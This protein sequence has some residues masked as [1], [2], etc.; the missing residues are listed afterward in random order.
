MKKV[1]TLIMI[2]A[3]T[4]SLAACGG[5]EGSSSS[6][7]GGDSSSSSEAGGDTEMSKLDEIKAAGQIVMATSPDYPPFEYIYVDE[8]GNDTVVGADIQL[9]QYIAD[10]LGVELVVESMNFD[11]ILNA[12]AAGQADFALSGFTYKP[13]RAEAF[14][15]AGPFHSEGEQTILIAADDET[16]YTS[17]ND[18]S[19][20]K[21]GA[22]GG[23]LQLD[24]AN[25]IEGA[26]VL[27]FAQINE[28][29]LMLQS[30]AIDGLVIAEIASA[31]HVEVNAD[32]EYSGVI[33]EDYEPGLYA[34]CSLDDEAFNQFLTDTVIEADASGDYGTWVD[35]HEELSKS[36]ATE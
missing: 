30:G 33:F 31:T 13:E 36:Q 25:G 24:L 7:A 28:G 20:K 19:G 2:L 4:L 11:A 8:D 21:L 17:V 10:A 26:E 3:L 22:Q 29:I 23:S 32:I 15:L 5:D 35:E 14:H 6:E 1:L 12:V 27:Q 9:G 18:F 34:I 16:G